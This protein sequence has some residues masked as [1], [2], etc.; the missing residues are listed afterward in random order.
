[1]SPR[2]IQRR[3]HLAA[4]WLRRL[5]PGVLYV[6]FPVQASLADL[7]AGFR[8]IDRL[9]R[10]GYNVRYT[11]PLVLTDKLGR[12]TARKPLRK[13]PRSRFAPQRQAKPCQR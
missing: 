4:R 13:K 11:L 9:E 12:K 5:F 8:R 6:T 7:L 10:L 1:M 2:F 3:L